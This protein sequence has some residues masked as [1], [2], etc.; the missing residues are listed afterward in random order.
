MKRKKETIISEIDRHLNRKSNSDTIFAYEA[1]RFSN[2]DDFEE[3]CL[4]K[5]IVLKHT[6]DN[7]T[8]NQIISEL[9]KS[10]FEKTLYEHGK[11]DIID[12]SLILMNKSFSS[13]SLFDYEYLKKDLISVL[14]YLK[15]YKKLFRSYEKNMFSIERTNFFFF[16]SLLHI[17]YH[18]D[19]WIRDIDSWKCKDRTPY[20]I[21]FSLFNHLFQKYKQPTCFYSVL[22]EKIESEN[23]F[24]KSEFLISILKGSSVLKTYNEYTSFIPYFKKLTK[25]EINNIVSFGYSYDNIKH[26]VRKTELLRYTDDANFIE[27]IFKSSF[28]YGSRFTSNNLLFDYLNFMRHNTDDMFDKS[29]FLPLYDYVVYKY[30]AYLNDGKKFSFKGRNIFVLINEMFIWHRN[31][32]KNKG[33][34]YS[35]WEETYPEFRYDYKTDNEF[36]EKFVTIKQI[37]NSSDLHKEGNIL[38][39]CVYS[40]LN[41]CKNGQCF[42][43]SC[44]INEFFKTKK[45]LTIEVAPS[46]RVVQIRGKSNRLPNK[47]ETFFI[48][49]WAEELGFRLS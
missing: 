12:E 5:G 43:F 48:K 37:T 16:S 3:F 38:N 35:S 34:N 6:I 36:L 49:K 15:K 45:I 18:K 7:K 32:R 21:I 44:E 29:M 17:V 13:I 47:N 31:L 14:F 20:K 24:K 26:I 25:K 10:R 30:N 27:Q 46:G 39:H 41:R 1:Y 4:N 8:H 28:A 42:I 40:Y 2:N 33:K 11:K 22:F 9:N 19:K 23:D